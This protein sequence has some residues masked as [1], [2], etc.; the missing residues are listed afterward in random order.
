MNGVGMISLI[1]TFCFQLPLGL[2]LPAPFPSHTTE[3]L[4]ESAARLLFTN[5][6]WAKNVPAFTGLNFNDQV[7]GNLLRIQTLIACF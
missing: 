3:T 2:T 4:C 7:S 6:K 1:G 5:V